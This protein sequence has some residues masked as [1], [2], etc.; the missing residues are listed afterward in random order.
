MFGKDLGPY[1][2]GP[3]WIYNPL[4]YED[5]KDKSEM[6][7]QSPMMHTDVNYNQGSCWIPLLQ[8]TQSCAGYGM[9]VHRWLRKGRFVRR[10]GCDFLFDDENLLCV[11]FV[12]MYLNVFQL[13]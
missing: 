7:I 2:A 6:T 5:A 11:I 13:P 12:Y 10:S 9:V 1:N 4:K 8:A 3:L